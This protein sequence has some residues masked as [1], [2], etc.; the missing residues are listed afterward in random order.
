MKKKINEF[1][2][3]ALQETESRLRRFCGRP[4]PEK[5]LVVV[6]VICVALATA[7]IW[8]LVSAISGIGKNDAEKELIKMQHIEQL[9][10]RNYELKIE[11][12]EQ[13]SNDRGE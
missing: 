13:Q 2:T 9:R 6:L 7:N 3:K 11:N 4:S 12:D 8:F 10:I 1:R 5:R